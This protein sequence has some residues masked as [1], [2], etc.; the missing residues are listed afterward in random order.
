MLVLYYFEMVEVV[1][2]TG[3]ARLAQMIWRDR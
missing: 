3:P 2:M 1:E